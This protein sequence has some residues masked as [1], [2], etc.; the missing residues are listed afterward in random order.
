MASRLERIAQQRLEQLKQFRE[1]G[2][3]PY[4]HRYQRSHTTE[5]AVAQLK[6]NEAGS[7][8][9]NTVSI[10]GRITAMRKMGKSSFVD[11]RDGSG[12]IQLLFQNVDQFDEDKL[13]LFRGLDIGD[14]IGVSGNL[15]RTRSGESTIGVEDFTLLAKSLRPLPE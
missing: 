2:T 11:I 14:F 7:T 3:D 5:E 10:A 4:P 8:Q 15:L 9:D 6:Q 1:R 13:Q 12:K